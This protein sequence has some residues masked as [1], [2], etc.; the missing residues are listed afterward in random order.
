[1]FSISRI[2]MEEQ[3]HDKVKETMVKVIKQKE[4]WIKDTVDKKKNIMLF[5]LNEK[6]TS[7]RHETEREE[8]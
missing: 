5:G 1:M 6:V 7:A 2:I 4:G 3:M 8:N